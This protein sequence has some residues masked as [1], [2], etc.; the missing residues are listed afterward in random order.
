MGPDMHFNRLQDSVHPVV[1]VSSGDGKYQSVAF[2][3]K[4]LLIIGGVFLAIL[5]FSILITYL[6][7]KSA[8]APPPPAPTET[9]PPSQQHKFPTTIEP[10]GPDE[11][12]QITTASMPATPTTSG[13]N[14]TETGNQSVS[15]EP[16]AKELRLPTSLLPISY[17]LRLKVYLPGYGATFATDKNFT[18]E[19]DLKIRF[20]CAN[21]TD[22]IMLN[23]IKLNLSDNPQSYSIKKS[24]AVDAKEISVVSTNVSEKLQMV[25]FQLSDMLT[26]GEEYEFHLT[27]SGPISSEV[28][29]G[30]YLSSY[31]AADGQTRYLAVTQMEPTDARRMVPCFD[32]PSM[33][34]TW[35]V[36]IVHPVG[37]TALS[38]GIENQEPVPVSDQPEWLESSFKETL[39]MSSYLLAVVV[40][41]F[42]K[43]EGKTKSGTRF[44][45][46][47]RKEAQH[48]TEYALT[49]GITALE[50]FEQ[51]YGIPFPLEKQ[52]MIA[53][54]DFEAGAMENWGLVTYREKYLLYDPKEYALSEKRRVAVVVAHEL[55]HQWFG[56]LV[57]MKWWDDLWLNEGFATFMEYL[58]TNEIS[59]GTFRM[60]D[61]FVI[62][63]FA[64]AMAKDQRA[65][66]HP[67]FVPIEKSNEINEVF[68][69][70]SYD[71]GGTV[72]RMMDHLV[73]REP[74]RRGLN[75][76][77]S[78][79]NYSNADHLDL[80]AALSEEVP[81]SVTD[82]NGERL[83]LTNFAASWTE[84]MGYPVV[85][86]T[87]VDDSKVQL[88]Q[89]RFKLDENALEK[90][91]FRNPVHGYKWDIPIWHQV[92]GQDRPMK[93]LQTD[94]TIDVKTSELLVINPGAY[95]F[96][97]VN[98]D[99]A[100][101]EKIANQ[102]KNDHKLIPLGSRAQLLD[103]A[104]SL[105]EANQLSYQQALA[106]T[107]YLDKEDELLPWAN[108]FSNLAKIKSYFED[109][110]AYE[111]VQIYMKRLL[112]PLYNKLNWNNI[113][114]D[115]TNDSRAFED[116]LQSSILA[117]YCNLGIYECKAT[118]AELFR[119]GFMDACNSS[120]ATA[121]SCSKVPL[122]VRK[123]VYCKGIEHG[124]EREW[125]FVFDMYKKERFQ[126]EQSRL[127]AALTCSSSR[128]VLTRL[129]DMTLEEKDI[130]KQ[131][132]ASLFTYVGASDAAGPIIWDYMQ[133]NWKK[134][135]STY[136]NT[137]SLLKYVVAASTNLKAE[138][139]VK[140]FER[141]IQDNAN[142]TSQ[143]SIFEIQ[144]E[145]AR[146]NV[147]WMNTHF[148]SLAE[149]FKMV[150]SKTV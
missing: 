82:W 45:I 11:E 99:N 115:Y 142:V 127:M 12:G 55:A 107:A 130:R 25:I 64:G 37:S 29:S 27:Y 71:K 129:L 123:L 118:A 80:W 149:W 62:D 58:G 102:L 83:D 136:K 147:K 81:E 67:L 124:G 90:E 117:M 2:S 49:S 148:Q 23:S 78:K 56:N 61:Y 18:F 116:S 33:K 93:W 4:V 108:A 36:T 100:T 95:G 85:E 132:A 139:N 39:K 84:Q 35:A 46:W 5:F 26:T 60:E 143:F 74:F 50:Y 113:P 17:N 98:Y 104:F 59:N 125:N 131:D 76:Y 145:K 54:P 88:K 43:R 20:L 44:R 105:A 103:D 72:L 92:D 87:R 7:T 9:V 13:E 47:A 112:E 24:N 51:F 53:I 28:L 68:D 86:V 22:K 110:P 41:D 122:S 89:K 16:T 141:F 65:T 42:D 111:Y 6:A 8:N 19:G 73:G 140:Q 48:Q 32:E 126:L 69:S 133:S 119:T 15:T 134:I 109:E 150:T 14:D 135:Y 120:N 52:D 94:A 106:L 63:A 75:L 79:F 1:A 114:T 3:R 40:S 10:G 70:I 146:S 34:A 91:R 77:L 137:K 144:L 128:W 66:S 121:S 101:W 21:D 57:T 30:L 97:R 96:Y 31:V 138:H 38:N